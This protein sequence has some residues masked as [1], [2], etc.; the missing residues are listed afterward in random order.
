MMPPR[1]RIVFGGC[2]R[3]EELYI[4]CYNI[5]IGKDR[6]FSYNSMIV[7]LYKNKDVISFSL[8][9]KQLLDIG[10]AIIENKLPVEPLLDMFLERLP[11]LDIYYNR[12]SSPMLV[13]QK[14]DSLLGREV[15]QIIE[16][17]IKGGRA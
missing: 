2:K 9:D 15:I 10:L 1:M 16:E 8:W 5:S 11:E 12:L 4:K 6:H 14:G 17:I 7:I 13:K 3:Q